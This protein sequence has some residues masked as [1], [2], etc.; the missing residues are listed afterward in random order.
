MCCK[1]LFLHYACELSGFGHPLYCYT[2]IL[3]SVYPTLT[4]DTSVMNAA[5]L[6][7]LLIN[8]MGPSE[9]AAGSI[10]TTCEG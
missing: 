10:F 9:H 5:L 3:F 6:Y 2:Q 1:L 4:D 7:Y 8:R